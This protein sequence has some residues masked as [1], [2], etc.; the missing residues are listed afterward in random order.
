MKYKTLAISLSLWLSIQCHGQSDMAKITG[1]TYTPLYGLDSA[2]VDVQDFHLDIY[3][4]TNA[5]FLEFI[6]KENKWQRSQVIRLYAD[7][8][9][10]ITWSDD[11]DYGNNRPDSPVNS[12]SWFAAKNYCKS[13][14]K[15]LPTVD[16]W[17]YVAMAD[18]NQADA[19]HDSLYNQQIL[20]WYESPKTWNKQIKVEKP[21]YWGIHDMHRI[22]WEWNLD[23]NS[24]LISGESRK[25]VDSDRNL[26]CA[27]GAVGV[28][29]LMNYAAFMRYAFRG[30]LKARYC[31]KNL[32]FRCAQSINK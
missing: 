28:N 10:L 29:D 32:G 4:V 19:R 8:N 2:D 5:E 11:L 26:F 31:V 18:E 14:G 3:P 6:S 7:E 17:E 16:E 23:F 20:S 22:V 12:V 24:I 13:I 9:Y 30:S 21:N 25:D 27:G 15:R 1:G